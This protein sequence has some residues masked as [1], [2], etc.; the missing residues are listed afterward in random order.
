ML[1]LVA[2]VFVNFTYSNRGTGWSSPTIQS[3]PTPTPTPAS[4]R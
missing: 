1:G 4:T 3:A 2:L